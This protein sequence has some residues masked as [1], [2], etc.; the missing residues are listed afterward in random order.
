MFILYVELAAQE[1]GE[2]FGLRGPHDF[3]PVTV[4]TR[5]TVN[6]SACEILSNIGRKIGD[7]T[8]DDRLTSF[9]F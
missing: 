9:L 2:I 7:N 6:E 5:G 4:E 3:Q 1:V 8:G